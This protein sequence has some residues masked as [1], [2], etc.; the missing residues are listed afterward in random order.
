MQPV[1]ARYENGTLL[2]DKPL[3]LRQGERVMV[4][5]FQQADPARWDLGRLAASSDEDEALA[6]AG[7]EDWAAARER[8]EPE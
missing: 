4:V 8:V 5:V 6:R 3:P 7:L 2:P 1:Q